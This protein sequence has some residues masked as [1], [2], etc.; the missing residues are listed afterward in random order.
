MEEKMEKIKKNYSLEEINL[1]LI[2]K[3]LTHSDPAYR[4]SL[5]KNGLL[6]ENDLRKMILSDPDQKI[7]IEAEV[8]LEKRIDAK[9]RRKRTKKV[10][11]YTKMDLKGI[12]IG[13]EDYEDLME[14][15]TNEEKLLQQQNKIY[16]NGMLLELVP[17]RK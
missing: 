14:E 12:S 15:K 17:V 3:M 5:F 6:T 4:R 2:Q 13:N 11:D 8:E 16:F 9:R 10:I 7:R 1:E